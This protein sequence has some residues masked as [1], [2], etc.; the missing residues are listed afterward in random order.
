MKSIPLKYH[1]QN[2]KNN[3]DIVT[4]VS[5]P[6]HSITRSN[7]DSHNPHNLKVMISTKSFKIFATVM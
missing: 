4:I 7:D 2:V 3:C 5:L 6:V 1:Y